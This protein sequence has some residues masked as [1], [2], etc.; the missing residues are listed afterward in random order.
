MKHETLPE[1]GST[2]SRLA[3][4]GLLALAAWGAAYTGLFAFPLPNGASERPVYVAAIICGALAGWLHMR[5]GLGEGMGRAALGGVS[6]AISALMYFMPVAGLRMT[7]KVYKF[8]QFDSATALIEFWLARMIE[9]FW[10][11]AAPPTLFAI[12]IGGAVAGLLSESA[13]QYWD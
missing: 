12:L 2:N 7:V 10:M 11:A 9:V 8:A 1:I 13:R 3:S 4:A 6:A 5:R